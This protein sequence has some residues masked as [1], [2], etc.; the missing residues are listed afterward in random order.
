MKNLKKILLGTVMGVYL[1]GCA[2]MQPSPQNSSTEKSIFVVLKTPVF[3]YADQGFIRKEGNKT[4]L[5]IYASGIAVM[6]LDISEGKVCNGTGLFSCMGKKEFNSRYL[7]AS[8]PEDT[9][10][11]ILKGEAIFGGKNLERSKKGF[12]QKIVQD[13]SH[14]IHYNVLNHAITFHDTISHIVIKVRKTDA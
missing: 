7:S 13:G 10:E 9:L 2:G 5:E 12:S 14:A 1:S 11:K 4:G 8:Y 3:N 6:K